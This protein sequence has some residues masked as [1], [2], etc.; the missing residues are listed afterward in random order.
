MV[1]QPIT[2]HHFKCEVSELGLQ[3]LGSPTPSDMTEK[4]LSH[5]LPCTKHM[6]ASSFPGIIVSRAAE[7]VS[8]C[9][10]NRKWFPWTITRLNQ[11]NS[12][13][14]R[15]PSQRHFYILCMKVSKVDTCSRQCFSNILDHRILCS[16][17]L[18]EL[19]F[20]RVLGK[21]LSAWMMSCPSSIGWLVKFLRFEPLRLCC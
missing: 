11:V 13:L 5:K 19:V 17:H 14:G 1:H 20:W 3:G 21:C 2:L 16:E 10:E 8:R 4:S 9:Y 6:Y 12:S 18:E 7:D 15:G